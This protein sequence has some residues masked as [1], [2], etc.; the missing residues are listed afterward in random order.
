MDANEDFALLVEWLQERGHT[1]DEIKKILAHVR[2][3]EQKMQHDSV[4]DSIGAGRL[5]LD[6]IVAEA[7]ED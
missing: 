5:S 3:Y 1:P 6:K 7:L 4:M 2:R